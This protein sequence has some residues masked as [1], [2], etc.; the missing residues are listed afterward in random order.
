MIYTVAVAGHVRGQP[1]FEARESVMLC[2]LQLF[3]STSPFD[4]D[5]FFTAAPGQVRG[6]PLHRQ[7][8]QPQG[9]GTPAQGGSTGESTGPV[10][11]LNMMNMNPGSCDI[12]LAADGGRLCGVCKLLLLCV[13]LGLARHALARGWNKA[14]GRWHD[15]QW[16]HDLPTMPW[17]SYKAMAVQP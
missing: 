6:Q 9:G 2:F 5:C 15:Q 10:Y 1:P 3:S 7:A 12:L 8:H 14:R 17:S 11:V 13:W 4:F 16:V